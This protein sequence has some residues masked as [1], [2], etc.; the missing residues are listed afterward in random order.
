MKSLYS[1]AF[2]HFQA[3]FSHQF[4]LGEGKCSPI[5]SLRQNTVFFLNRNTVITAGFLANLRW[6]NQTAFLIIFYSSSY[7]SLKCR[8]PQN[9]ASGIVTFHDQN[10]FILMQT[11][12]KYMWPILPILGHTTFFLYGGA[13]PTR[14]KIVYEDTPRTSLPLFVVSTL[15]CL[16]DVDIYSVSDSRFPGNDAAFH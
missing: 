3:V 13:P 4:W 6:R 5:R 11:Y 12:V 14:S 15:Y 16:C 2:F 8:S 7:L 10:F 9:G 1:K